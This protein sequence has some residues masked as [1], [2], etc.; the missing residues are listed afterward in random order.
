MQIVIDIPESLLNG[1]KEVGGVYNTENFNMYQTI[2]NATP[3]PKG[4]GRIAD[5]DAA[6]KCIE[7]V[8]GEEAVWAIAL[9]EWACS[10]RTLIETD[11]SESE[12]KNDR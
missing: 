1:W 3:L 4:H 5:M 7:E 8:E 6:I 2:L 11:K 12:D 9:I 10:K